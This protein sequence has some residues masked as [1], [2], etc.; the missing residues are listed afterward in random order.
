[1]T[2]TEWKQVD[3]AL[4]SVYGFGVKLKID[5]FDV[6]LKLRQCSQFKNAIFVYIN[7]EFRGKWLTEDC[8]ERRRFFP[9]KRKSVVGEKDFKAYGIRSKK[10]KQLLLLLNL[11]RF[12]IL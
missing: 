3:N 4:K 8:E 12:H 1:M 5:N 7:G 2:E 11:S 9:C 10:A 6:S